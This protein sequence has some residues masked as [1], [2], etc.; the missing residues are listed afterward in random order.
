[1]LDDF[2]SVKMWEAE[3]IATNSR[4]CNFNGFLAYLNFKNR[5]NFS[6]RPFYQQKSFRRQKL[7]QYS[8]KQQCDMKLLKEFKHKFHEHAEPSDVVVA[9]GNWEQT[10]HRY[11]EPTKGKGMRKVFEMAGY[12]VFLIDE[13]RTSKQCSKCSNVDAQC[14]KFRQVENPRPWR[15]GKILCHGLVRCTTCWTMWNRDV[16]AAVNIWKI[17]KAILTAQEL[18]PDD[19]NLR[20]VYL[21]RN[22]NANNEA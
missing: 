14:E 8:K 18:P 6:L 2:R 9:I 7:A 11:H 12:N 10:I 22:A 13:F 21:R 15:N 3:G 5:L 17:A 20:P 1:M 16:N 19:P 4:T